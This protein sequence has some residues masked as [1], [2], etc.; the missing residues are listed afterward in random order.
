MHCIG[1]ID[2][3]IWKVSCPIYDRVSKTINFVFSIVG[4]YDYSH[5]L[6][7]PWN[8]RISNLE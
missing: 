1:S 6:S 7:V 2:T 4:M 8:N 3:S 5:S